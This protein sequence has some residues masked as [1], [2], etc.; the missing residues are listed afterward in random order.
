MDV[1]I[2]EAAFIGPGVVIAGGVAIGARTFL[3][4]GVTVSNEV[5]I[6]ADC[7]VGAHSL[8]LRDLPD[9]STAYG[10]LAR[11]APLNRQPLK[12]ATRGK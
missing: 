7:V 3:G 4:A 11:P 8:V 12:P 1:R 10:T 2:G 9:G 6:G 5:T